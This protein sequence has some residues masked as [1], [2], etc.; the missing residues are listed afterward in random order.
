MR[1]VTEENIT[2]AVLETISKTEN[3]RL[4]VIMTSL[5]R[6]L[7]DFVREVELTQDEWMQAIAFLTRVGETTTPLRNEFILASD[8]LGVSSLVDMISHRKASGVT[9]SS[10]LGPFYLEGSKVLEVGGDVIGDN[11]GEPI[12]VTGRVVTPDGRP[13]AGAVLDVWQ[14]AA[15]GL[16]ENQDPEQPESNLRF[17][18]RT[19]SEGHYRFTTTRPISYTVPY[20]GPVGEMLQAV[21]RHAWRPAHVH[22]MISADGY[23]PLITELFVDDDDYID[24]D[25]VFGVRESLVVP[26][27]RLDTAEDAARYN[28]D[29]G[30]AV[31]EF[32][33][34]LQP[35]A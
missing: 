32:D 27:R 16:Y 9:D 3:Q 34:A 19:D 14:N 26:F 1:N 15:N 31:V 12:L 18:M 30:F 11:D 13:I 20:D 4:K 29:P 22:F 23:Q 5:I 2:R 33:F 28:V 24:A 17:R 21:G 35:Q 8:T 10:L 7:H 6:H 25:A